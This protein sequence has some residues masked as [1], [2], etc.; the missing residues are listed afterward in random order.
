MTDRVVRALE[1][2]RDAQSEDDYSALV[3]ALAADPD[4]WVLLDVPVSVFRG[5][6]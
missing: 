3:S 1:D 6:S 2:Q 4:R 5:A